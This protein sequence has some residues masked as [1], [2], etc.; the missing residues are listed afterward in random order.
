VTASP[1]FVPLFE[2]KQLIKLLKLEGK[3]ANSINRFYAANSNN[4]KQFTN[5]GNA[6][7]S[8]IWKPLEKYLPGIHTVY[9]APS[10]LLCRIAFNALPVD[11]AG[12]S[13]IDKYRLHQLLSTRSVALPLTV[14]QK[15]SAINIWGDIEYNDKKAG[16]ANRSYDST[17]INTDT[18]NAVSLNKD[19]ISKQVK[20]WPALTGTRL[21][22][23]NIKN[24]FNE[25]GISVS[26]I[27]DTAAT[28]EVF[29]AMD[30]KSPPVLHIATH[31]FFWTIKNNPGNNFAMQQDPMFRSGL[32]L[33]GRNNIANNKITIEDKED[34]ILTSYEIAQLDLSNTGLVVLSAC[35]TALG[36]L[37]G[38]E[39]VIGLQSALK[40]TGVKQMIISLWRIP[41]KQTVELMSLFY[42]NWLKGQ[43]PCEALRS[44]QII[45]KKKY[46]VY[47]WAGFVLIE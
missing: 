8:L 43:I 10:G 17:Q 47:D 13:L 39:G 12:H 11:E 14:T 22:M 29:K 45:M 1:K 6:L 36:D 35:E 37:E 28:E 32:V 33:A 34:G 9:Y 18:H 5:S 38:N 23:N 7:Y 30:G 31:G 15:P 41:D 19:T 44:A 42:H 40:L 20:K 16:T 24:I 2:E 27:T 4:S 46:S 3:N 21:E 26:T 25:A